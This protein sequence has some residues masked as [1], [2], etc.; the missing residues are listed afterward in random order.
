[1]FSVYLSKTLL[2]LKVISFYIFESQEPLFS[3]SSSFFLIEDKFQKDDKQYFTQVC[4]T[5]ISFNTFSVANLFIKISSLQIGFKFNAS[6]KAFAQYVVKLSK[7]TRR[8]A[9]CF[10]LVF[11]TFIEAVWRRTVCRFFLIKIESFGW[12]KENYDFLSD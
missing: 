4:T 2:K 8:F 10:S 7:T 3:R 5:S 1:M 12:A 11:E 6:F 9:K